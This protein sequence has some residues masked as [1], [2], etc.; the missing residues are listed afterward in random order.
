MGQYVKYVKLTLYIKKCAL[1]I[2]HRNEGEEY[3]GRDSKP[4]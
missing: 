4:Q 1:Y 3:D 2:K